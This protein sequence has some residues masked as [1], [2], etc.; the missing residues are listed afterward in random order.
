VC[1]ALIPSQYV[2]KS[3]GIVAGSDANGAVAAASGGPPGFDFLF[4]RCPVPDCVDYTTEVITREA[5]TQPSMARGPFGAH[6]V[7]FYETTADDLRTAYRGNPGTAD[8][9]VAATVPPSPVLPGDAVTWELRAT[10]DGPL[11]AGFVSLTIALAPGLE[12]VSATGACVPAPSVID[13]NAPDLAPGATAVVATVTVRVGEVPP[14]DLQSTVTLR[15]AIPDPDPSDNALV[16]TT[17]VDRWLEIEPVTAVEPDTGVAAA[18]FRITLRDTVPPGAS[19]VTVAFATVADTAQDGSDYVAA[20]G[21]VTFVPGAPS[22]TVDVGIVGD[23]VAE[24]VETF[25]LQL[26]SPTGAS[27]RV[28]SA[29]GTILDDDFGAALGELQHGSVQTAAPTPATSAPPGVHHYR[30]A[31]A[32]RASYEVVVDAASGD[33][34]PL[35][36]ARMGGAGT[37][38]LQTGDAAG[39]GASVSLAWMSTAAAADV[40]QLVRV[41]SGGC[42]TGC[43]ADDVYRIRAYETTLRGARFNNSGGQL[44]ALALYNPS[45]RPVAGHAWFFRGDGTLAGEAALALEPRASLTL[46]TSAVAPSAA[47][48]VVVAHDAPYGVLAGKLVS[49]EPATGFAFDTPLTARPR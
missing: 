26:S 24:A 20:S 48:S 19:P 23:T 42:T 7:V 29:V 13:C 34:L 33:L 43:G 30:I 45:D 11:A 25:A 4:A 22:R 21:S 38:V 3:S 47:G 15:S 10:N 44:T 40:S 1:S 32:P 8:L 12:L 39:T 28:P 36:V 46:D 35:A 31:Q 2:S 16:L 37:T 6:L 5:A 14:G 18:P 9:A 49:L 27:L 17:R 41:A